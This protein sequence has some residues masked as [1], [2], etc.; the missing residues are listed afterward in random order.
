M[1]MG[2][3]RCLTGFVFLFG[4]AIWSTGC[5][6]LDGGRS[7]PQIRGG[8]ESAA[9]KPENNGIPAYEPAR[10]LPEMTAAE[11]KRLGDVAYAKNQLANAYVQYETSLEKAPENLSVM[12]R[13]GMILL[14][15]ALNDEAA[16][17]FRELV[18]M[19]P[20]Y[21]LAHEGLGLAL[22]RQQRTEEAEAAFRRAVDLAPELWKSHTYLAMI[23]ESRK[24]YRLAVD[25]YKQALGRS[26]EHQAVVYNNLGVS[27]FKAGNYPKAAAVFRQAIDQGLDSERIYNNLGR[28]LG[29]SGHYETALVAFRKAGSKSMA[30]N[31]M[32][33][34][35]LEQ[36]KYER[37][38]A[39][40]QKAIAAR[41]EYYA[42]AGAN[43]EYARQAWKNNGFR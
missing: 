28:A 34:V 22:F 6:S 40:F 2:K 42:T 19:D 27:Y 25:A 9:K 11:H 15:G 26:P 41:P 13:Q 14:A 21:A 39:C 35:F 18:R 23:H 16:M 33:C 12:Y 8:I 3:K 5:A 17:R 20:D 30:Y 10:T 37:A 29:M 32:G 31:N 1:R 38:I 24:E 7:G 43:L 36:Q 4:I